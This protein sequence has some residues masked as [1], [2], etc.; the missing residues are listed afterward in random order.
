[1]RAPGRNY[2][3]DV[4]DA[5]FNHFPQPPLEAFNN[6]DLPASGP[7]APRRRETR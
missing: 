4:V 6:R 1:V 7:V 3:L 2:S 5:C